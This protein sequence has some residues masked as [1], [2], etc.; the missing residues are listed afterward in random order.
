V[1]DIGEVGGEVKCLAVKVTSSALRAPSPKEKGEAR[2]R[3]QN[4]T[5]LLWRSWREATDEVPLAG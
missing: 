1:V 5:L 3:P 4:L 2:H